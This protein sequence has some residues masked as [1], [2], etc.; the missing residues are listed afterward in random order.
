MQ[1]RDPFVAKV[2]P[3]AE[4]AEQLVELCCESQ[5]CTLQTELPCWKI[6]CPIFRC[7]C[8]T[9]QHEAA[10]EGEATP[11][12]AE[13]SVPVSVSTFWLWSLGMAVTHSMEQVFDLPA[14]ASTK[15]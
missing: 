1:K 4:Q 15:D 11:A 14:L 10:A 3:S 9:E 12:L 13:L 2:S 8:C 5:H 6:P 7:L